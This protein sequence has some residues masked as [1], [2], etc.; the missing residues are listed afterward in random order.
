MQYDQHFS[1]KTSVYGFITFLV[2]RER[3]GTVSFLLLR[4]NLSSDFLKKLQ[5]SFSETFQWCREAGKQ[6]F[7]SVLL[8]NMFTKNSHYRENVT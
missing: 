6:S 2:S 4:R 1:T 8:K 5:S 3:M 7:E